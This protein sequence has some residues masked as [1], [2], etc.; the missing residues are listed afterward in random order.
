[1]KAVCLWQE[2]DAGFD[3]TSPSDTLT[4][5]QVGIASSYYS[6]NVSSSLNTSPI[7]PLSGSSGLAW[8]TSVTGLIILVVGVLVVIIVTIS[9][10]KRQRARNL[11]AKPLSP[12]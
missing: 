10:Y 9:I 4:A 11:T 2:P 5:F 8:I 7:T 12:L 6:S 3:V 1:I